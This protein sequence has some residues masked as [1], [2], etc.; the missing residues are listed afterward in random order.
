MES[1]NPTTAGAATTMNCRRCNTESSRLFL[2]NK[3]RHERYVVHTESS[4]W[5]AGETWRGE[6]LGDKAKATGPYC[7]DCADA[8]VKEFEGKDRRAQRYEDAK[9]TQRNVNNNDCPLICTQVLS[10]AHR[11]DI[12]REARSL[13][14]RVDGQ[15]LIPSE[16]LELLSR[17][18]VETR[19][20]MSSIDTMISG[21]TTSPARFAKDNPVGKFVLITRSSSCS[22]GHIVAVIDGEIFN[23]GPK[24]DRY[25]RIQ[26][27]H[28]VA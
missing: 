16:C 18:G 7:S 26:E 8:R 22:Y 10:G 21:T 28:R 2:I 9:K 23:G 13:G 17:F 6:K 5:E 15:G 19:V 27:S 1:I 14:W 20:T 3:V 11:R 25:W 4:E 24:H 12:E